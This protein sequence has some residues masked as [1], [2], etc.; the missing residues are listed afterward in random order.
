M[1]IFRPMVPADP[2]IGPL[3][4][5]ALHTVGLGWRGLGEPV[6]AAAAFAVALDVLTPFTTGDPEAFGAWWLELRENLRHSALEAGP[7]G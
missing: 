2:E 3:L 1:A 6:Q 4:A 5:S 7:A